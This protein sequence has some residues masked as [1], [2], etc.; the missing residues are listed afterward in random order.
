MGA[1]QTHFGTGWDGENKP[2]SDITL[3]VR[4][5]FPIRQAAAHDPRHEYTAGPRWTWLVSSSRRSRVCA[6]RHGLPSRFAAGGHMMP[7]TGVAD[8]RAP[9]GARG[10]F[11]KF[12]GLNVV[13]NLKLA[14]RMVEIEFLA[15]YVARAE[16]HRQL[17]LGE[18]I[19]A[20][21]GEGICAPRTVWA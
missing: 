10:A 15:P 13:T 6:Q 3:R 5:P 11:S 9:V 19:A 1:K 12:R 8:R 4:L 14:E 20:S 2:D 17:D 16:P 7:P 18:P 21:A